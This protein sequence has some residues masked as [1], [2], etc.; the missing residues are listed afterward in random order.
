[1]TLHGASVV[2]SSNVQ[3]VLTLRELLGL[4]VITGPT[5]SSAYLRV[6]DVKWQYPMGHAIYKDVHTVVL[7]KKGKGFSVTL[8]GKVFFADV[9]MIC[10]RRLKYLFFPYDMSTPH[11]DEEREFYSQCSLVDTGESML[12]V[13]YRSVVAIEVP[14]E[15]A[16][17]EN[18]GLHHNVWE[19][20][21]RK[22]SFRTVG[23]F[24][25]TAEEPE[26]IRGPLHCPLFNSEKFVNDSGLKCFF[27][28]G[29]FVDWFFRKGGHE[30]F[31]NDEDNNRTDDE[32]ELVEFCQHYF[33]MSDYE[34]EELK[35]YL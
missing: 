20:M 19:E 18:G 22:V 11:P 24:P 4:R 16:Y 2:F 29:D 7:E 31:L 28:F 15:E 10:T 32:D 17:D 34:L 30:H 14:G 6:T 13:E 35:K 21:A 3:G 33:G 8:R 9:E 1:M 26:P 23:L 25:D 12:D 5:P 27:N